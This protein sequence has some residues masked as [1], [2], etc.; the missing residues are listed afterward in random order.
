MTWFHAHSNRISIS[1][2]ILELIEQFIIE[3]YYSDANRNILV[4][5]SDN[6]PID[7]MI[8]PSKDLYDFLNG[9]GHNEG[10]D[11]VGPPAPPNTPNPENGGGNTPNP[12]NGRGNT[13]EP[14][15]GEGSS[16]NSKPSNGE[17]SSQNSKPSNGEGSSQNS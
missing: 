11:E 6:Y 9:I 4:I 14:V 1:N 3:F 7:F 5:T 16:Q 8:R 2:G 10:I 12:E 13:P 15:N 17:G